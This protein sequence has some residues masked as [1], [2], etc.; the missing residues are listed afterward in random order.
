[1]EGEDGNGEM[2]EREREIERE[3][4]ERERER[5][6]ERERERETEGER[7]ASIPLKLRETSEINHCRNLDRLNDDQHSLIM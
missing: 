6:R 1:M 3:R 2:G 7:F 5:G 4:G